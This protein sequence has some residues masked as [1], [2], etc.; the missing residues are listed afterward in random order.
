VVFRSVTVP[1]NGGIYVQAQAGLSGYTLVNG[2]QIA[3]AGDSDN[4]GLPDSWEITYFGNIT[5]QNGS[6]DPDGDNVNNLTEYR[7]GRN[8]TVGAINDTTGALNLR[9]HTLLK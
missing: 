9:V 4:D 6:G 1:A 8:P 2:M 5:L 3:C 7:Q